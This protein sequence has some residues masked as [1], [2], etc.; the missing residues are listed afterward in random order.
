VQRKLYPGWS[1]YEQKFTVFRLARNG[2][3]KVLMARR[4]M[5]PNSSWAAGRSGILVNMV[6]VFLLGRDYGN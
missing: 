2:L 5:P 4:N 6:Q 3:G 1:F